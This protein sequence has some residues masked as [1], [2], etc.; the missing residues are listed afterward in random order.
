MPR[1]AVNLTDPVDRAH[2]LNK[3]LVA[4]WLGLPQYA[5]GNTWFDLC[6]RH[7]SQFG[8]TLPFAQFRPA[9]RPGGWGAYDYD[10]NDRSRTAYKLITGTSFTVSLWLRTSNAGFGLQ[11]PW[12]Q[13]VTVIYLRLEATG[14]LSF[15]VDGTDVSASSAT[16]LVD[17]RWT[18]ACLTSAGASQALY[19]NAAQEVT[20]S[21][22]PDPAG[23]PAG[24]TLGA[25]SGGGFAYW[26]QLDDA[27]VYD[28]C[29]TAGEVSALYHESRAG[30][31]GCLRRVRAA[32]PK[33]AGAA[34]RPWLAAGRSL[35]GNGVA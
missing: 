27:R 17:G 7:E 1:G 34:F 16:V 6:R 2:P 14:K 25:R 26:G 8:G 11:I 30:Y 12:D 24:F 15:V 18:H 29:L 21:R 32:A 22:T 4:W 9:R 28:R 13:G 31:P 5:G 10:G 20:D 19:V 35:L 23:G 33:A 3:G